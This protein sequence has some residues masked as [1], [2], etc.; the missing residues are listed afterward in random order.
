MPTRLRRLLQA[1][2]ASQEGDDDGDY[3]Q[4]EYAEEEAD[5]IVIDDFIRIGN[6]HLYWE[7]IMPRSCLTQVSGTNAMNK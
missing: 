6:A 5:E 4:D 3:D 1:D 2:D 7:D